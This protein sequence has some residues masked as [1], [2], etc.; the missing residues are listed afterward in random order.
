MKKFYVLS[1]V[2]SIAAFAIIIGCES[3]D[4][5]QIEITPPYSEVDAVG[6]RVTLSAK[7]WSDYT[8]E[9]DDNT[10]GYLTSTHGETVTYVVTEVPPE[11]ATHK[12]QAVKVTAKNFPQSSATS[13]T[14][15][16]ATATA[17]GEYTGIARVKHMSKDGGEDTSQFAILSVEV[18][19]SSATVLKGNNERFFAKIEGRGDADRR[20]IWEINGNEEKTTMINSEGLLLVSLTETASNIT[21]RA[22]SAFNKNIQGT[23]KVTVP[24]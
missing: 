17:Q 3:A 1:L 4:S 22:T 21:V 5:Y 13:G 11:K 18:T 8:W 10:I 23:A 20:V 12:I 6:A 7:G 24:Q 2:V 9:L 16:T 14:N 19:P 15:R